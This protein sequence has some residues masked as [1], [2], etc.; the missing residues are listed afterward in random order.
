MT[1]S[2]PPL[3]TD[4]VD[5]EPVFGVDVNEIGQQILDLETLTLI[6]ESPSK[7]V[8]IGDNGWVQPPIGN[9]ASTV[10]TG[11][12][13]FTVGVAATGISA[14]FT[15]W[16]TTGFDI[17]PAGSISFN[18]ALKVVS[19]TA[20][21]TQVNKIYRLTFKGRTT[22]TLDPGGK[23]TAD[24]LGIALA[25]GDVVAIRTFLVSGTAYAP[26][27]T[28]GGTAGSVGGFTTTTDLTAPGA[29]AI[30]G[31]TGY[32]YGPAALLGYPEGA[33]T[34]KSVLLLGDSIGN[35]AV[36]SAF[37][38]IPALGTGGF[39]MRALSGKG[40]TLNTSVGGA[41]AALFQSSDVSFRRASLGMYCTSAI[42]EFGANDFANSSVTWSQVGAANMDLANKVRRQGIRK[43]F[44]TTTT[45]Y[46]D[47]TDGWATVINQTIHTTGEAQRILYNTWLRANA[48]ID[49]VTLLPVLPGTPLAITA[50]QY[51][52][53]IT[54]WFD[55]A[56][57]VESSLNSG[58]WAAA[59]R[60]VTA[61]I[62]TGTNVLT[63][64]SGNFVNTIQELGGD[65]GAQVIVPG[66]GTNLPGSYLTSPG[67]YNSAT[68][69]LFNVLASATVTNIQVP[70]G[71]MTTEGVHG[72]GRGHLL[73]SQRIDT[74]VFA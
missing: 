49:P 43:V 39:L 52:H 46:T 67:I 6:R 74:S 65:Q 57:A 1:L 62:T 2:A 66:A 19:T 15:H 16:Y 31:S 64:P 47:S 29:A 38:T 70:I 28:F 14:L 72:S 44:L 42:I 61:S 5:D 63:A 60:V 18:A 37:Y 51:G 23:V 45:P 20:A 9:A 59:T 50:G 71:T 33:G 35:G 58:R 11:E 48:P 56:A 55:F 30:T 27:A 73:M 68:Q 32:Y 54:G 26:R 10:G 7:L 25:P 12:M 41:S 40:G 24:V 53:P 69:L 22:A 3:R 4:W 17:N 36:D 8:S 21:G 13:M 34:A